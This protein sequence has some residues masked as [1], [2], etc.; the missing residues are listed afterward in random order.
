MNI[1]TFHFFVKR[2]HSFFS[3]KAVSSCNV[4]SAS[5]AFTPAIF[6]LLIDSFLAPSPTSNWAVSGFPAISP[7]TDISFS[8][9]ENSRNTNPSSVHF[10]GIVYT[11]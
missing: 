2:V 7:Q 1:N 4:H 6:P 8:R 11:L 10:A 9:L 5:F 3:A